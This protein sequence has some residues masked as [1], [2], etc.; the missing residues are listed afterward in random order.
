MLAKG[1]F[2]DYP[3]FFSSSQTSAASSRLNL[4]YEAIFADNRDILD[5]ARVL[6]ISS[7]DGRW[8][9]AALQTGAAHVTGV[10]ARPELVEHSNENLAAYEIDPD[11]YDFIAGD[12]FEVLAE[13]DLQVDVVLCLGFLYHTLRYNELLKLIRSCNPRHVI[14]DTEV[15]PGTDRPFIE[16]VNEAVSR[17][18]NAVADRFSHGE[19]VL[20]GRPSMK[21]IRVMCRGYDFRFDTASDW[22]GLLRDNPD[23]GNVGDYRARK[24][25][26]VRFRQAEEHER[27]QPKV[28]EVSWAARS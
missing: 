13:R 7:H 11:R 14:F 19:T 4:R 18:G 22:G 2:D 24:R 25:T 9:F 5:G 23:A 28:N 3:R 26:T 17:E 15:T 12:V 27:I 21:A 1:F 20:I 6:D 10:E 8:S 16:V